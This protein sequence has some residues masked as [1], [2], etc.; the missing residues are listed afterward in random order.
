MLIKVSRQPLLKVEVVA[1]APVQEYQAGI[2]ALVQQEILP[3]AETKID[4]ALGTY[5]CSAYQ[6]PGI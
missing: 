1:L 2:P 4:L 6:C 3:P 5:H